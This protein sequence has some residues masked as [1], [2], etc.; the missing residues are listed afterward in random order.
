MKSP[1]V[2]FL[3]KILALVILLVL[4]LGALLVG[5]GSKTSHALALEGFFAKRS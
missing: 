4:S 5:L 3:M 1:T 2:F